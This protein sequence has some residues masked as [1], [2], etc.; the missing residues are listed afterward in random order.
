MSGKVAGQASPGVRLRLHDVSVA[1][2]PGSFGANIIDRYRGGSPSPKAIIEKIS[3]LE[4]AP[5]QITAIIGNSG[6][7]KTTL[8]DLITGRATGNAKI[9]GEIEW[10]ETSRPKRTVE[11]FGAGTPADKRNV[12]I[13]YVEQTDNKLIPHLT[14]GETLYYQSKLRAPPSSNDASRQEIVDN[15]V[16][17]LGLK[18]CVNTPIGNDEKKGCSGGEKRR[19][20]LAIQLLSHGVKVICLD[21]PMSGLDAFTGARLCTQLKQLAQRTKRTVILTIHQPRPEAFALFDQIVL[22]GKGGHVLYAGAPHHAVEYFESQGVL[23]PVGAPTC[24]WL[25][26][27]ASV[28]QEN[29]AMYRDS[30]ERIARLGDAWRARGQEAWHP[31]TEKSVGNVSTLHEITQDPMGDLPEDEPPATPPVRPLPRNYTFRAMAAPVRLKTLLRGESSLATAAGDMHPVVQSAVAAFD[32]VVFTTSR[33]SKAIYRDVYFVALMVAMTNLLALYYGVMLLKVDESPAGLRNRFGA[34]SLAVTSHAGQGVIYGFLFFQQLKVFDAERKDGYNHSGTFYPSTHSRNFKVLAFGLAAM[35]IILGNGLLFS[36]LLYFISGLSAHFGKFMMFY[37]Y[38]VIAVLELT[39]VW[40]RWLKYCNPQ[41]WA[42]YTIMNNE[43]A[44][45]QFGTDSGDLYLQQ[46]GMFNVANPVA[47]IGFSVGF[48][49][50]MTAATLSG[51]YSIKPSPPVAKEI[52]QT[53]LTR[54]EG[55][56]AESV[57]IPLGT[58][59]HQ[60]LHKSGPDGLSIVVR[61]F[62]LVSQRRVGLSKSVERIAIEDL[63]VTFVGGRFT[64]ILG[65]SGA[66]K[67][68]LLSFISG[69]ATDVNGLL[70]RTTYSGQIFYGGNSGLS[71]DAIKSS[72][73]LVR[74]HDPSLPSA[75]TVRETLQYAA[76]LRLWNH[77]AAHQ[78]SRINNILQLLRLL[79]CANTVVGDENIKGVSGGE[80]RRLSIAL[81]LLADP[82][83][84]ILDEPTTGLDSLAARSVM[85]VLKDICTKSGKTIICSLHN[86]STEAFN[87]LDDV[88]LLARGGRVVYSG[89][90]AGVSDFFASQDM[91]ISQDENPADFIVDAMS[92]DM[93]SE[94]RLNRSTARVD[95][96]VRGFQE[97]SGTGASKEAHAA[98]QVDNAVDITSRLTIRAAPLSKAVP[99]LLSR[100]LKQAVRDPEELMMRI[101][102][103]P[104]GGL[105]GVAT[106]G[107]MP[108]SVL[109]IQS[110][111]GGF[112]LAVIS[113]HGTSMF[114]VITF[115]HRD[116]NLFT[117]EYQE[118]A[119]NM[120]AYFVKHTIF[121]LLCE[122]ISAVATVAIF[123]FG[124]GYNIPDA[125]AFFLWT[126]LFIL[127]QHA[128]EAT[129]VIFLCLLPSYQAGIAAAVTFA[130]ATVVQGGFVAINA[131]AF[132]E[133]FN[134]LSPMRHALRALLEN[135]YT[136][137]TLRGLDCPPGP[138]GCGEE[139][140]GAS[141][142]ELLGLGSE[143]ITLLWLLCLVTV[144]GH[145]LVASSR[146]AF[147]KKTSDGKVEG[148]MH[149]NGSSSERIFFFPLNQFPIEDSP[150]SVES[151]DMEYRDSGGGVTSIRAET[152]ETISDTPLGAPNRR[153]AGVR[154]GGGVFRRPGHG[155]T[156]SLP[157]VHLHNPQTFSALTALTTSPSQ[158]DEIA[159]PV[160]QSPV[161]VS[162]EAPRPRIAK[163]IIKPPGSSASPILSPNMLKSPEERPPSAKLQRENPI[164][165]RAGRHSPFKG[166]AGGKPPLAPP[167]S[168]FS[169][170]PASSVPPSPSGAASVGGATATLPAFKRPTKRHSTGGVFLLHES[171]ATLKPS[172]GLPSLE[173]LSP[174]SSRPSGVGHARR[175]SAGSRPSSSTLVRPPLSYAELISEAIHSSETGLL[176]LQE[177]YESIKRSYPYFKGSDT[178]WQNSIRHNLSVNDVFVKVPRPEDRP[179]K[180]SLWTTSKKHPLPSRSSQHHRRRESTGGSGS[181]SRSIKRKSG[182]PTRARSSSSIA[183][184][185]HPRLDVTQLPHS[186]STGALG[187][188]NGGIY[189]SD[190]RSASPPESGGDEDEGTPPPP[191]E[192]YTRRG[193]AS[194]VE[195]FAAL[196]TYELKSRMDL[197]C[198]SSTYSETE[199]SESESD[200][201]N[202]AVARRILG[203]TGV[204]GS[205]NGRGNANGNGWGS[206]HKFGFAHGHRT[207]NGF[208]GG[209]LGEASATLRRTPSI[210]MA[211]AADGTGPTRPLHVRRVSHMSEDD[212]EDDHDHVPVI[213][214]RQART[215]PHSFPEHHHL[216]L[217]IAPAAVPS[218]GQDLVDSDQER[219]QNQY[220]VDHD[221]VLRV[222]P[223]PAGS[224][225]LIVP[226]EQLLNRRRSRSLVQVSSDPPDLDS[227]PSQAG[228]TDSRTHGAINGQ[229]RTG[230]SSSLF[231]G[232]HSHGRLPIHR[233]LST[234]TPDHDHDHTGYD[235]DLD[236]YFPEPP[237]RS[238]SGSMA[239]SMSVADMRPSLRPT[240]LGL[241]L[242]INPMEHVNG[243]HSYLPTFPGSRSGSPYAPSPFMQGGAGGVNGDDAGG[244]GSGQT[245]RDGLGVGGGLPG[246]GLM[247]GQENLEMWVDMDMM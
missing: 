54:G 136:G 202:D 216:H 167:T 99:T 133:Y 222:P 135:E 72:V 66:G 7:G 158:P 155:R 172:S 214:G 85:V 93:V 192:I 6:A 112:L 238:A 53:F 237:R 18:D 209:W 87:M 11:R 70:E 50:V 3:Y 224:Q 106:W 115:F 157:S 128:G 103:S 231:V 2:G 188:P 242:S 32:R 184:S 119:Y 28:D 199:L 233:S 189:G 114:N 121:E 14:V 243:H 191:S 174:S 217:P 186:A 137:I 123:G 146:R 63:S 82:S 92:I 182:G 26:D 126:S 139:V 163:L 147:R 142:L 218:S 56:D 34:A 241:G 215:F 144:I 149:G 59:E 141:V 96:L 195:A 223:P 68:S 213:D 15:L 203:G 105:L 239:A 140:S 94:E 104:I 244:D 95:S 154:H 62:R 91:P 160:P 175:V 235:T 130:G 120:S 31:M 65:A 73:A 110:R 190:S 181:S 138:F 71:R 168:P 227:P 78:E 230:S 165:S 118:R 37:L 164:E 166:G 153:R 27:V 183:G 197:D 234:P 232:N 13:A 88:L 98:E 101:T 84:L 24:E 74:Q 102:S 185:D 131:P 23:K 47:A 29:W 75:L 10:E 240:G 20:S 109:S 129:A 44:G 150:R 179:G 81:T 220:R 187:N 69:T 201:G 12:R 77:D 36:C 194:L 180:G 171:A 236:G 42:M 205:G 173:K 83:V 198:N 219:E 193:S 245:E 30:K 48:L 122:I 206:G 8:L 161:H 43:V 25:V 61:N 152:S 55:D 52:S 226:A 228:R 212:T 127:L 178:A 38:H 246:D 159:I 86:P 33:M 204:F 90:T 58:F 21:E 39:L 145:R 176:S 247:E 100:T 132:L 57:Q 210:V 45:R 51:I 117:R 143:S 113:G 116:L 4:F 64:G 211:D 16:Q 107:R 177:I 207:T 41:Y 170:S 60:D 40:L 229:A 79:D 1:V 151:E 125:K 80:R 148:P 208:G 196:P 108:D 5:S 124:V 67:T 17:Q 162:L 134:Y 156:S 35:P 19:V 76:K 97:Y 89:S 200:G 111:N 46:I 9:E 169:A 22:L 225:Y 221:M 49:A